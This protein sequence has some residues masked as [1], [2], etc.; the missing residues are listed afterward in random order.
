M[1]VFVTGADGFIGSHLVERLI[2]LGHKVKAATVTLTSEHALLKEIHEFLRNLKTQG[3][4][5][6]RDIEAD[7][8]NL[9]GIVNQALPIGQLLSSLKD[10]Q[11]Q[12]LDK[13]SLK[14]FTVRRELENQKAVPAFSYRQLDAS[15]FVGNYGSFD[16]KT[17]LT[18]KYLDI[19]RQQESKKNESSVADF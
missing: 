17:D 8:M 4:Q 14:S 3:L 19:L 16:V 12:T 2:K 10:Y 6:R 15:N 13:H 1:K 9:Y 7:K 18:S 5:L 11:E